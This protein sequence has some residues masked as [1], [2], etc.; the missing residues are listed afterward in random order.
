VYA[1]N[2]IKDQDS[3]LESLGKSVSR[4]GEL[5]LTISREIDTQ[6]KL[7][8]SLESDVERSQEDTESIMKKTKEL[9]AK[10]GGSKMVCIIVALTAVLIVLTLMVIYS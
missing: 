7:L 10:A 6:N 3:S 2:R 9:V 5:S 1:S 4:L 8:S